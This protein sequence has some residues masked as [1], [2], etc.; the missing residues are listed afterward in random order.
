MLMVCL[1]LGFTAWALP[2]VELFLKRKKNLTAWSFILCSASLYLAIYDTNRLVN[3]PDWAAIEDTHGGVLFGAT[4][5]V[6]VTAVLNLVARL[7]KR[8]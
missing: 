8:K 1:L 4:V 2:V 5:L 6:V 7:V 3:K